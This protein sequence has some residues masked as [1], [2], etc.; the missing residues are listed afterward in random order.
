MTNFELASLIITGLSAL[1]VAVS[2]L[3]LVRQIRIAVNVH[4]D[5]HDWNRRIET[6]HAITK[7]R[8]LDTDKLHKKFDHVNRANSIPLD[9]VLAAFSEKPELQLLLHKVLNFY[10]GLANGVFLKTYDERIIK[11]NRRGTMEREFSR[12]KNYIAYRRDGTNSNAWAGYERILTKW[13]NETLEKHDLME[14]GRI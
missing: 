10:E 9:D 2:V 14:T 7:I 6:Q 11:A 13:K 5:N 3:L 1:L 12:F 4:S 8:E